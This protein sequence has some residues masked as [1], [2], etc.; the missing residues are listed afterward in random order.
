MLEQLSDI[1]LHRAIA[2][3][4]V[5]FGKQ[6]EA[7]ESALAAGHDGGRAIRSRARS[8]MADALGAV[9]KGGRCG[10]RARPV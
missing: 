2:D 5:A 9:R 10:F 1:R 4:L 8:T 7:L 6:T 3:V